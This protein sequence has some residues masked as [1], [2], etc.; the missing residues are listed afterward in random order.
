M[1]SLTYTL[2]RALRVLTTTLCV[3]GGVRCVVG[4][5]FIPVCAEWADGTRETGT[6]CV[7]GSRPLTLV[8]LQ[9]KVQR[10]PLADLMMIEQIVETASMERPWMFKESGRP[11]KIYGE[12]RAPLINFQTRLT[13]LNG[14]VVT[15]H[16]ISLALTLKTTNGVQKLF[17]K[18]QIKGTQEE[19]IDTLNYLSTLRFPRNVRDT[20]TSLCGVVSGF[21]KL[22]AV[23]ALDTTREQTLTATVAA[24]GEFDFG[25][26][27]AGKYDLCILTDSHVLLGQSDASPPNTSGPALQS[28]DLP[29]IKKRFALADDF[30]KDR[31]IMTLEG[32][33]GFAKALVYKRRS[34]YHDASKWTP[35]GFL[36]HLEIWC[37]HLAGNDWKLDRR[38]ILIRHKQMG[39]E[40]N[41]TLLVFPELGAVSPGKPL[42]ITPEVA[43]HE[44]HV[45]RELD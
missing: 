24:K 21:G 45:I 43:T 15:G 14:S 23:T 40:Q 36:W 10:Y 11:E 2:R 32:H 26:V 30:F 7:I 12:H 13:L 27:L 31:V 35:G 34:E 18:R 28:A 41:R 8:P 17:L 44:R 29:A 20:E 4:R 22:L 19:T 38:H 5:D 33:R 42:H 16:V 37:W 6:T 3:L 25:L 39:G 9:E 1:V